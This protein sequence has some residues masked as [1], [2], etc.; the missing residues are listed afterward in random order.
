MRERIGR[1]RLPAWET[2]FY[3]EYIQ[4]GQG[5][6]GWAGSKDQQSHEAAVSLIDVYP[7]IKR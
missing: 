1:G 4:N 5:L 3:T 2:G 7:F 6:V